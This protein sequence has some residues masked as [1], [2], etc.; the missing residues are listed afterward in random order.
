MQLL[1]TFAAR[2]TPAD[3]L[4]AQAVRERLRVSLARVLEKVDIIA[5]PTT[6]KTAPSLDA[7]ADLTGYFDQAATD[8]L[9]RYCFLSTLAGLP[10]ASA[11]VGVDAN[12]LH[13]GLQVIG[14]AWDDAML[15]SVLADLER[16]GAAR[17]VR[18]SRHVDL[19]A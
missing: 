11:P 8:A 14:N 9:C 6:T 16:A 1:T 7:A 17:A 13:I 2:L 19:L 18:P 5:L 15:L 3:Y 10:A 4:A 12:G